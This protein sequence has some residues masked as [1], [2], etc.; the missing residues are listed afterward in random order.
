LF[1][2]GLRVSLSIPP[3]A[4]YPD[5]SASLALSSLTMFHASLGM[6]N[7]IHWWPKFDSRWDSRH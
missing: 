6:Q 1:N 7:D 2:C 3:L 4:M 5:I